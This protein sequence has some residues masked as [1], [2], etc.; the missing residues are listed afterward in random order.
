MTVLSLNGPLS[1]VFGRGGLPPTATGR[2]MA[3]EDWP[4][5]QVFEGLRNTCAI[6][7]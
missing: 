5:P 2:T 6:L 1:D 7:L 4:P 3:P